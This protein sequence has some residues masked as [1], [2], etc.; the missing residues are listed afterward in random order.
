MNYHGAVR[1]TRSRS[2]VWYLNVIALDSQGRPVNDL[3]ADDFQVSDAGKPQKIA[4]FRHNDGRPRLA[5]ALQPNEHSNR[6]G[7]ET[8]HA[9][10]I[11]FDLL[12]LGFGSRGIIS[13]QL[14]HDLEPLETAGS[15]YLYLLNVDGRLYPVHPLAS[16]EAEARRSGGKPWTRDIKPM[17]D[18]TLRTILRTRP[19]DIDVAVRV[20][21]TYSA[22][23]VM[24]LQLSRIPGRK[25]IVWVTDGVP[26]G[27]GPLRSDTGEF[28]DFTPLLRQLSEGLDRSGVA[29][30][31][32]R[33][34]MGGDSIGANS[35]G[36]GATGGAGTGMQSVA[37]LDEFATLTGGRPDAGRQVGD[38]VKQ[39]MNDLRF[40]Y[41]LGYYPPATA[42]DGKFH[43]LRVAC[44]R[45]G[46][47]IQAK[48]GYYAW[49]ELPGS[50]AQQAIDAVTSTSYDSAEI[51]LRG[52]L[53]QDAK[54]PRA[55]HLDVRIDATDVVL[56]RDGDRYTGQLR[57]ALVGY[58][59]DGLTQ[60]SQ[61]LPLDLNYN[62][63]ER[64][65]ALQQ[66]IDFADNMVLVGDINKVRLV[67]YDRGSNAI[68]TLT[69]L[70]D[71]SA[72]K[73][74]TRN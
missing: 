52:T 57:L 15:L 26:I 56:S 13:H 1:P 42:R 2:G 19:T 7:L 48:T 6:T 33:P 50:E 68:G 32:L 4:F 47:R 43:K 45:K 22:L 54:D 30:Y 31:P 39:A 73:R 58:R 44:R 18:E 59:A 46:V 55:A 25:N 69:I 67:V 74:E 27:L 60:R 72:Q 11:L 9:T 34:A 63:Q 12:N 14:A 37:T 16:A 53:S 71:S 3:T 36:A 51:G 40:S 23:G 65:K 41:Q 49:A 24:A 38:T 61:V 64:D 20:Q 8:P 66:G 17:L 70:I 21:L 10:V 29:L 62:A 28:I 5:T 35:G